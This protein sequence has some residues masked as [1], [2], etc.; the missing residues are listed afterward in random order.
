MTTSNAR[1]DWVVKPVTEFD[2]NMKAR[3]GGE[4][5]VWVMEKH[6]AELRCKDTM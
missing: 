5:N 2:S 4:L 1:D 6:H 3:K